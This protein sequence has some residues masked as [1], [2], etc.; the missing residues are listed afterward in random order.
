[1]TEDD[2]VVERVEHDGMVEWCRVVD[3]HHLRGIDVSQEDGAEGEWSVGAY[4]MEY[5]RDDPLEDE[6]PDLMDA[7]LAAV[8]GVEEAYSD[9]RGSWFVSGDVDPIDLLRAGARVVDALLD[10]TRPFAER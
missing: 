1:L 4:V 7:A 8:P 2:V 3:E 10:R 6:L 9:E 5:V